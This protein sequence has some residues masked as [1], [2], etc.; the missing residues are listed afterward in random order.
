MQ[1][2]DLGEAL[3]EAGPPNVPLIVIA[4]APVSCQQRLSA[5]T[6]GGPDTWSGA[7]LGRISRA[8]SHCAPDAFLI[9][10]DSEVEYS[11]YRTGRR[12]SGRLRQRVSR[13]DHRGRSLLDAGTQ[14]R[15][16]RL[17]PPRDRHFRM[18]RRSGCGRERRRCPRGGRGHPGRSVPSMCPWP[19]SARTNGRD[20]RSGRTRAGSATPPCSPIATVRSQFR[21]CWTQNGQEIPRT[22][23]IQTTFLT[24]DTLA[25]FYDVADCPAS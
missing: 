8:R 18:M 20:V 11:Q 4:A 23:Y 19:A 13:F 14:D 9:V 25:H 5:P 2:G 22:M 17:S 15:P 10:T 3:C 12:D 16:T 6:I 21:P 7:A 24:A 1:P